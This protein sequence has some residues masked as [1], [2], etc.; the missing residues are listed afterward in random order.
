ML[1]TVKRNLN[2]IQFE[3]AEGKRPPFGFTHELRIGKH[4]EIP[5]EL[6]GT[7]A[8]FSD[9]HPYVKA[10]IDSGHIVPE[11]EPEPEPEGKKGKKG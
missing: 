5:K 3:A 10:H 6:L 2:L 11:P 8:D 7:K 4:V 1:F 9:A